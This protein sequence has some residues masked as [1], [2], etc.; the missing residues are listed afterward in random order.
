LHGPFAL[1]YNPAFY[2]HTNNFKFLDSMVDKIP[3]E[4]TVMTH[5]NLAVR[6]THQKV[7]LLRQ[8]YSYYK[9][10]Y[11]LIDLRSG[12]NPNNFYGTDNYASIAAQLKIDPNYSLLYHTESQFVFKIR[13]EKNK[14][15]L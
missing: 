10:D 11:I 12:Q 5:N 8:N 4:A 9:P 3:K 15:Q 1:A 13:A 14:S 2:K 7:W 6:F